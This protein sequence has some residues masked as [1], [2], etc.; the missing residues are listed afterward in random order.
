MSLLPL[1]SLSL[2][3][4]CIQTY[5]SSTCK[6]FNCGNL[7]IEYPFSLYDNATKNCG[8]P[9]FLISCQ[10][11]TAILHLQ[12]DNYTVLSIDYDNHTIT[13][14]D[15]NVLEQ[16]DTCPRV[17]HNVSFIA[18][19]GVTYTSSD[20]NLIFFFG[21][22]LSD[23]GNY[24]PITC[25][26]GAGNENSYVLVADPLQPSKYADLMTGCLLTVV[27]PVLN[28]SLEQNYYDL[29]TAFGQVLKKGFQLGWKPT[30]Y[31]CTECQKRGGQC[32]Y[33]LLADN[34]TYNFTCFCGNDSCDKKSHIRVIIGILVSGM[35]AACIC[36]LCICLLFYKKIWLRTEERKI[37]KLI[38]VTLENFGSLTPKRYTFSEIKKITKSFNQKI[39]QG[40]YANVFKGNLMN[41]S[42]VAVKVLKDRESNGIEF[43]SEVVSIARTSHVNIV[44]LLGFSIKGSKRALIYEF[45]PNGSLDKYLHE[46]QNSTL[47]NVECTRQ[48]EIAVGIARGLEYL[49]RGCNTRIVHFDIKPHNILLDQDYCPKI[50]DFGLAKFSQPKES[51]ISMSGM[52]GTIGYIA[53]E[54]FSRNFGVVSSKSDVYSYGM[55]VL[56]MFGAKH[57]KM[58][59]TESSSETYFP[60]YIY[61]CVE[62][63]NICSVYGVSDLSE[64]IVRKVTI[65]GLWCVQVM[66][67]ARPTMST[68]LDML[69]RSID[70][71]TL[72][73]PLNVS[74]PPVLDQGATDLTASI[75]FDQQLME[76][77][78]SICKYVALSGKKEDGASDSDVEKAV[79]YALEKGLNTWDCQTLVNAYTAQQPP[80]DV[81]IYD[82]WRKLKYNPGRS[83]LLPCTKKKP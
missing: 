27:V 56:E 76:P 29:N 58:E 52:R 8:L 63:N 53:P 43:T 55:M 72:P 54:V 31:N 33:T 24:S 67:H 65:V 15:T 26:T 64:E 7:T 13:L 83:C 70:D 39:G 14:V 71:L 2:L 62:Q 38:E 23:A 49:H 22:N 68:V 16:D 60:D 30:D 74:L 42:P 78:G 5:S 41:G 73:P 37:E 17:D 18:N 61:K 46:S 10:D 45:M 51:I 59:S 35:F 6:P 11:K 66:P 12:S 80:T 50:S 57:G 4:L 9:G 48:F 3:L 75:S 32:A 21:C 82:I 44:R 20:V 40:G 47:S 1:L 77:L 25:F 34:Y 79:D 81:E 36:L 28:Y 19:S 69:D